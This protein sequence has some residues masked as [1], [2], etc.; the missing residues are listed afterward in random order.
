MKIQV[1]KNTNAKRNK[2]RL[3]KKLNKKMTRKRKQKKED[4]KKKRRKHILTSNADML[5][6][7]VGKSED[8]MNNFKSAVKMNVKML[9][10]KITNIQIISTNKQR[11][12]S[13]TNKQTNWTTCV[14]YFFLIWFIWKNLSDL[15]YY[16]PSLKKIC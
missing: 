3:E 8:G 15:F 9:L 10:R 4:N 5:K 7:Q 12:K 11:L 6:K 14:I 2:V 13:L 16:W 1:R